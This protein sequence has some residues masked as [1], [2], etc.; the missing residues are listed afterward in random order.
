MMSDGLAVVC[1]VLLALGLCG[2]GYL[3]GKAMD[4]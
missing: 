3:I 4:E 2:I 1:F